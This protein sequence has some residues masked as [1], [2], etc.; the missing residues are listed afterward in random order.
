MP[1]LKHA[2]AILTFFFITSCNK[3]VRLSKEDFRWIPY[4]GN[5]TLVFKSNS[6]DIDTIFLTGTNR[7]TTPT[8]PLD[9]FP[10][11][12]EHFT[13]YSNRSD[14]SPPDGRHRYLEGKAFVELEASKQ[15]NNA[16]LSF[17][18]TAKESWY[19]GNNRDWQLKTIDTLKG[20]VL[21]TKSK[22]Y[23]D[24]ITKV[25]DSHEYLDRSEFLTKVY[26][27]KSEGLIRFDKKDSV[28]WELVKKYGP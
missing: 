8:D 19:Y 1:V 27:S 25:P 9:M 7:S 5:E 2:I 20:E 17:Y 28:H 24:I 10:T 14:P 16:Y 15:K 21:K 23:Y 11:Y 12:V 13:I 22:I 4:K 26:W 6:G 3:T 18:L